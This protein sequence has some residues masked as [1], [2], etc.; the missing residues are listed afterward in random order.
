MLWISN[1]TRTTGPFFDVFHMKERDHWSKYHLSSEVVALSTIGDKPIP[2]IANAEQIAR[3]VEEYGR[4]SPFFIVRALGDF[5]ANETSKIFTYQMVTDAQE[6]WHEYPLHG[7]LCIGVDVA[8]SGVE[9]DEW[10]VAIRRGLKC[11]AIYTKR[12]MSEEA[13]VAYV[14]GLMKEHR[15]GDEIPRIMVDAEGPIGSAFY[16]RLLQ[17]SE[18]LRFRA[19]AESYDIYPVKASNP[20]KR[21][22]IQYALVRDELFANLSTWLKEGA[23]PDDYKLGAELLA[24]RWEDAGKGK[25]KATDKKELRRLLDRSPDRFDALALAVWEPTPWLANQPDSIVDTPTPDHNPNRRPMPTIEEMHALGGAI[26]GDPYGL[27]DQAMRG[28]R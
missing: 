7:D 12:G 19:P 8:G 5:L 16:K 11:V 2:G 21:W 18:E 26:G 4:D 17:I 14:L 28:R 10:A 9:G 13:A 20:A 23:I 6:R 3:W 27:L 24:P 22:P 25:N 15:R 1:P